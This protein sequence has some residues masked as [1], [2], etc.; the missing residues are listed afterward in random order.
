MTNHS[1]KALVNRLDFV[2]TTGSTNADL[3]AQAASLPDLSVLVADY[4][5]AGKGRA[6]R[7]WVA[8][9]GSSLFVSILVKPGTSI[10]PS[11][12]S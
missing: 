12:F 9:A 4:Q 1:A 5:S 10:S 7:D 6:G 2:E 11:S 3:I 8:P